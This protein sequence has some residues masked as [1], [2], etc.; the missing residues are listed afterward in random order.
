MED[1]DKLGLPIP[2][3]RKSPSNNVAAKNT[4][5]SPLQS[6]L[7]SLVGHNIKSEDVKR[8]MRSG[9]TLEEI[10]NIPQAS[11]TKHQNPV[12]VASKQH[13]FRNVV[14]RTLPEGSGTNC[15]LVVT[16]AAPSR[17]D[18]IIRDEV[19]VNVDPV[20]INDKRNS[21]SPSEP[22]SL[23]DDASSTY[24]GAVMS[25][26]V[27][28][29]TE[30][31]RNPSFQSFNDVIDLVF[32]PLSSVISQNRRR[33]TE[34]GFNLDLTYMT[35]RIIA[36]G[37]PARSIERL[38]R[39][40]EKFHGR[41][42]LYHMKDHQSPRLDLMD[43]FCKEVN[44][45]LK[46]DPKNVL[47]AHC[48]A[49]K[50]RAGIMIC[51]YL[52]SIKFYE[53]PRQLM[54]YYSIAKTGCQ[55]N[56][57]VMSKKTK[58]AP[59]PPRCVQE[60][61]RSE[62]YKSEDCVAGR[63]PV[64][65]STNQTQVGYLETTE[66]VPPTVGS[67][68]RSHVTE[69][70]SSKDVGIE[71][72]REEAP[73]LEHHPSAGEHKRFREIYDEA[74]VLFEVAHGSKMSDKSNA[75]SGVYLKGGRCPPGTPAIKGFASSPPEVENAAVQQECLDIFGMNNSAAAVVLKSAYIRFDENT[76]SATCEKNILGETF[77]I[78]D[79]AIALPNGV[80]AGRVGQVEEHNGTV[81]NK[82]N[83]SAE[84]S[85]GQGINS[86]QQNRC[87]ENFVKEQNDVVCDDE[88]SDDVETTRL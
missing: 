41:V 2:A 43:P 22:G 72:I 70:I 26:I 30:A 63:V 36:I 86:D 13:S 35:D 55:N 74:P 34:D 88:C 47:A 61:D 37:Y 1:T 45:Y 77:G 56:G 16:D 80:H 7:V 42:G 60:N 76:S 28:Q 73:Q 64:D 57:R 83:I 81:D 20:A 33:Y 58:P 19:R 87:T 15:R 17:R 82:L 5:S 39:N 68:L 3:P 48:K 79:T 10:D 4:V 71:K 52:V 67:T 51:A 59:P 78:E 32:N 31:A 12:D 11:T 21:S 25:S 14:N 62:F 65:S 23:N 8:A 84:E 38:Y 49:G 29:I 54:D 53:E 6:R 27:S 50:G 40:M 75:T 69:K 46:A 66:K 24:V 18:P 85:E 9:S 44:E